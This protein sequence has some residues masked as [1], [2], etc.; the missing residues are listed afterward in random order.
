MS[1]VDLLYSFANL[2]VDYL[3]VTFTVGFQKKAPI[4]GGMDVVLLLFF[5]GVCGFFA[6]E[7]RDLF[8]RSFVGFLLWSFAICIL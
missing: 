7:F 3:R 5:Y 1:T 8:L 2:S 4:R 6:L